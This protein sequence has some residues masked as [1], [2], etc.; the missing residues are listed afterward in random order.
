MTPEDN[1]AP[2]PAASPP[3]GPVPSVLVHRPGT[4]RHVSRASLAAITDEPEDSIPAS[5]RPGQMPWSRLLLALTIAGPALWL[6]GVPV[7]AIPAFLAVL[8]FLI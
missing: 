2:E 5:E 4:K 6:G 1:P 8:I 3:S 7:G